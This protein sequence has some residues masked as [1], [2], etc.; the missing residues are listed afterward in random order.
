MKRKKLTNFSKLLL[1]SLALV[2]I[3][4]LITLLII[5]LMPTKPAVAE[6]IKPI[7]SVQAQPATQAA[8]SKPSKQYI[9]TFT[10]TGYCPCKICTGKWQ[11][12]NTA[13][14]TVPT[15]GRTVGA[16][17]SV[18]P[19]GTNIYIEGYGYRTVEDKPADWIIQRYDG[20]IIDVYCSTHQEALKIGRQVVKVYKSDK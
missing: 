4:V 14:G 15:A 8:Q 10:I 5:E 9:G 18:L 2:A 1:A 17:W 12:C 16:D 11:G 7:H 3:S 6:P 20:K 19:A 13:S